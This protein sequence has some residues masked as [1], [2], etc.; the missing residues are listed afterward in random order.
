M[1]PDRE[2]QELATVKSSGY[3]VV[4]SDHGI[5]LLRRAPGTVAPAAADTPAPPSPGAG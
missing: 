2:R 1:A 5:T 4:R 3:Q